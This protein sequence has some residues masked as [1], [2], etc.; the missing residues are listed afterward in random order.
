MK[1]SIKPL[2]TE[3]TLELARKNWYTFAAPLAMNKNQL[4]EL[5][6][7]TF[8]VQVLAAKTVVLKGKSRRSLRSRKIRRLANWKK[9][10][11]LVKEGQ[12]IDLFDQA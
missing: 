11:V 10:M 6:E 9:L 12:K 3:K 4:Q 1:G 7:K 5:I 2:I 8:K